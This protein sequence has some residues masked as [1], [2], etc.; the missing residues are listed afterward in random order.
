[1]VVQTGRAGERDVMVLQ[2]VD[3][4]TL[5]LRRGGERDVM[6]VQVS[7]SFRWTTRKLVQAAPGA[8]N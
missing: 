7:G 8:A 5:L 2:E 1:M 3:N 6:V 4:L